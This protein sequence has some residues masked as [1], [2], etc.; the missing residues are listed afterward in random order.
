MTHQAEGHAVFHH[1]YSS[2]WKHFK[3]NL[4]LRNVLYSTTKVLNEQELGNISRPFKKVCCCE[5]GYYLSWETT[6]KEN[7]II[8]L[9]YFR[10]I[11]IFM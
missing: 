6:R 5:R 8:N 9:N 2:T 7:N 10:I 3:M 4:I 1:I 11:D